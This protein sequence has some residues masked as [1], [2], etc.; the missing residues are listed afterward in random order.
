MHVEDLVYGRRQRCPCVPAAQL[1]GDAVANVLIILRI[2]VDRALSFLI[3]HI[4][5]KSAAITRRRNPQFAPD[6]DP[7]WLAIDT[8]T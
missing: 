1:F 5:I 4:Q 6:P 8:Y 7:I 3:H 2:E